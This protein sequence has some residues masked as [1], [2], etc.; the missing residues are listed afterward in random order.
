MVFLYGIKKN[1]EVI[2]NLK[3]KLKYPDYIQKLS[4]RNSELL[5][6]CVLS[7]A[8]SYIVVKKYSKHLKIIIFSSFTIIIIVVTLTLI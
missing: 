3:T 2:V 8:Y 5:N 6:D 1:P 7:T 4:I